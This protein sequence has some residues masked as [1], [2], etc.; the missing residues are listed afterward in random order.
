LTFVDADTH[1]IEIKN[2]VQ[3]NR[4]LLK[5]FSTVPS[6]GIYHIENSG[7]GTLALADSSIA[8][9]RSGSLDVPVFMP[10]NSAILLRIKD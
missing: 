10:V 4:L 6:D 2:N 8:T 3:G 1:R 5:K 9:V 7:G